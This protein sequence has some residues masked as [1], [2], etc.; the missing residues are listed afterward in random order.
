MRTLKIALL[1]TVATAALSSA[2]MA[3][4][5]IISDPII[6]NTFAAPGFDWEGPYVGLY[7]SGQA[8]DFTDAWGIGAVLGAN[9]L[10]DTSLLAGLEGSVAWLAGT[11][12]SWQGQVHGKLGFVM[13]QAAIYG[14]LGV[15]FNSETDGYVPIGVG[16]EFALADN[17]TIKAEYQYQ[18]D[19]E[20]QVAG[21]SEDAHVGKVGFNWH[22]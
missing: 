3:A 21:V 18:W 16:A 10:L 13:D 9:V 20:D 14:L 12:D 6:D 5:L 22:F 8:S 11:P 4:D 2:T 19:F 1:A 15:G 17:F 7:V